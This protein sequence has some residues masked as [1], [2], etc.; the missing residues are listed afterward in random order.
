M[1]ELISGTLSHCRSVNEYDRWLE[2]GFYP[3]CDTN[4]GFTQERRPLARAIDAGTLDDHS[5][6][7]RGEHDFRYIF[8]RSHQDWAEISEG[9]DVYGAPPLE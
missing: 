6:I 4:I 9:E 5:I 7:N 3:E 1:F 2:L 8:V